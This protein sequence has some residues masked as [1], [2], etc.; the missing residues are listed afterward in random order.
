M[1]GSESDPK[2]RVMSEKGSAL[3]MIDWVVTS[4]QRACPE[5][6]VDNLQSSPLFNFKKRPQI[7]RLRLRMTA[8]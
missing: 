1:V 3:Q 4:I 8:R 6:L 7:L 2:N 5:G